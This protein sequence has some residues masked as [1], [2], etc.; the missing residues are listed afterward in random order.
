MESA[1]ICAV[2]LQGIMRQRAVLERSRALDG[3]VSGLVYSLCSGLL[4]R[5]GKCIYV[6]QIYVFSAKLRTCRVVCVF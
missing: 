5:C 6:L 4:G 1:G 3:A 2:T